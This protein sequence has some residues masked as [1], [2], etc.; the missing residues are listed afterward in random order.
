M[1][2]FYLKF[3]ITNILF[4][5]IIG[6]VLL[7]FQS[8]SSA[9][10]RP[11]ISEILLYA[12]GLGPAVT[13]LL[14]YFLLLLLPHKSNF[15]YLLFI[16]LFYLGLI[17]LGRRSFGVIARGWAQFRSNTT[18][19]RR[20]HTSWQKA[21]SALYILLIVVLLSLYWTGYH[22]IVEHNRLIGH[23]ALIYANFGKMYDHDKAITYSRVMLPASNGFLFQGTPKPAFS[24]FLTWEYMLNHTLMDYQSEREFNK[25]I[26]FDAYYRSISG[27]YT[28]LILAVGFL[29]LY[30]LH[31]VLPFVGLVIMA[32]GLHFFLMFADFH[33]DSI[34]IFFLVLSWLALYYALTIKEQWLL[35]LLAV[36]SGFAAFFHVIGLVIALINGFAFFLC[37]PE[38][39]LK[40]TRCATLFLVIMVLCGGIHYLLEALGGAESGFS[41]Y[42]YRILFF[43]KN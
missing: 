10:N 1:S 40:K 6:L 33:I 29:W 16:G 7:R 26:Y 37:A 24:L 5:F 11:T 15:F 39:W 22:T 42:I 27:F 14:L 25:T 20:Q 12:L 3:F 35:C 31:P 38:P 34:R 30:R 28:L 8:R 4:S 18:T 36:F 21:R 17:W 19:K 2:L 13:V 32:S 43:W 23:D 9:P 41:S